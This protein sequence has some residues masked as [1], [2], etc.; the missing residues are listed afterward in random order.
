M[1]WLQDGCLGVWS[2]R[3]QLQLASSVSATAAN[4]RGRGLAGAGRG[5]RGPGAVWVTACV[6]VSGR[7]VVATTARELSFYDTTSF[8]CL[9]KLH[10]ESAIVIEYIVFSIYTELVCVACTNRAALCPTLHGLWQRG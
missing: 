7:L 9:H 4:D 2:T 3:F 10:S 1:C 5:R 8:S 6:M